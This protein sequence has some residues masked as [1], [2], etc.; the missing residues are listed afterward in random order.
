MR[1]LTHLLR[2]VRYHLPSV[3]SPQKC[4][5]C[6]RPPRWP[7]QLPGKSD[8]ICSIR[9]ETARHAGRFPVSAV[10][11]L[12][13]SRALPPHPAW[14][15]PWRPRRLGVGLNGFH[16]RRDL[17]RG[18]SERSASRCTSSATTE[19]PRPAS[20]ADARLNGGVQSQHVRLLGNVRNQFGDFTDLLRRFTQALDPLGSVLIWSRMESPPMAFCTACR[21]E[22]AACSD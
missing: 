22:S 5:G 6:C 18:V 20:P 3:R 21:P 13:D 15:A 17:A 16:Q 9:S 14:N 19:K 4:A 11:A 8:E 12:S 10:P 1:E 2:S 7:E